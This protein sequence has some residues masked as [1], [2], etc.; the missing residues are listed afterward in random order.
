MTR[1]VLWR[2]VVLTLAAATVV[3]G[4]GSSNSSQKSSATSS[5]SGASAASGAKRPMKIGF[6]WQNKGEGPI[7]NPDYQ[8]AADIAVQ[9]INA[10]GG[11]NGQPVQ[12]VRQQA[13]P[14]DPAK[15]RS[16][17]L[18]MKDAKPDVII[19][20]SVQ[21]LTTIARDYDA[22]QIPIIA[23]DSN[24][25]LLNGGNAGSKWLY[26]MQPPNQSEGVSEVDYAVKSLK[27]KSLGVLATNDGY[28]TA[29]VK[30][31]HD[32]AKKLNVPICAER[33]YSPTA[34]DL[35]AQVLAVKG[36]D[37]V[38]GGTYPNSLVTE[39]NA[40]RD[41]KLDTPRITGSAGDIPILAG[42]M[43]GA[44]LKNVYVNGSCNV[45]D[46]ADTAMAAYVKKFT[47]KSGGTLPGQLGIQIYDSIKYAAAL[48]K[49][50]PSLT[51]EALLTAMT[52]THMPGVCEK[53]IHADGAHSLIHT[54]LI[55]QADPSGGPEKTMQVFK[56]P[57]LAKSPLAS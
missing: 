45:R 27:A 40:F 22:A 25:E 34:T 16:E 9:E 26:L 21:S 32:E 31:I 49:A 53:D 8:I 11:V 57:D 43:K 2:A 39:M 30:W 42:Q 33:T 7:A 24:D 36:C 10:A 56:L 50:A 46:P 44:L 47:P 19:G 29:T 18:A 38:V 41:N 15:L 14:L 35:T 54:Q 20:L 51:N 4:C 1:G 13:D 55:L 5:P 23:V 37:A 28:G 17:F 3:A 52:T 6:M 12:T 48:G